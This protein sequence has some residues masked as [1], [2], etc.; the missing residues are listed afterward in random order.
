MPTCRTCGA[1]FPNKALIDGVERLLYSR[2][3][4]LDCLPH[5]SKASRSRI[6]FGPLLPSPDLAYLIGVIAGDGC[7]YDYERTSELFIAC[8]NRY[9]DLIV[10]YAALV[11][12]L[13]P[14]N[15]RIY[16]SK[17]RNYTTVRICNMHL[18]I[19]LG[20]P[21]GSKAT[22][23]FDIPQWVFE[24]VQYVKP[25]LR[26]LIETDGGVY[27]I[28]RGNTCV[29]HCHFTATHEKIMR[30]FVRGTSHLGY[31]FIVKGYRV[32]LSGT[33]RVKALITD[34]EISKMREYNYPH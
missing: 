10:G 18:S 27:K 3:Q 31:K 33:T 30:A 19:L 22:N 11:A 5:I 9:P 26:G 2:K 7:I 34:L 20:L 23:G 32:H 21:S 25:F 1:S 13:I 29:W 17:T 16:P 4:C 8:D 28:T 12:R 14:G 24:D 15:V 6:S